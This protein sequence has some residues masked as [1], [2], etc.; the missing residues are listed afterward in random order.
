MSSNLASL[1]AAL[2]ATADGVFVLDRL[3]NHV[4]SN[5]P[6]ARMWK[7]PDSMLQG[8]PNRVLDL[9]ALQILDSETI[10][11]KIRKIYRRPL[12]ESRDLLQTRDGRFIEMHSRPH[13]EDGAISGRIWTFQD[14]SEQMI[15][16]DELV[17]AAF[18]DPLTGL[19]NRSL[20]MNSLDRL[21][22]LARP[23]AAM[24]AV[25]FLDLD[26]FKVINDG[27]GHLAGDL[28][29]V[30][31]ARKLREIVPQECM[32]ARL[33]GDEFTVL[34]ESVQSEREIVLIVERILSEIKAP[35]IIENHEIFSTVSIG[36]AFSN[37]SYVRPEEMIRDADTAMYQAKRSG[38]SRF[39]I[40]QS[41]MRENAVSLMRNESDLRRALSRQELEIHY[42]PVVDANSRTVIGVEALV[43]WQHPER[44]FVPPLEFVTLAEET[45]LIVPL[46]EW[47]LRRACET[48]A[49]LNQNGHPIYMAVNLSSLQLRQPALVKMVSDALVDSGVAASLLYLELTE[50]ALMDS[51]DRALRILHDLREMGVSLAIDDFGTGYSSL[52]YLKRFPVNGLKI[53][54][55]FVKDIPQEQST[56]EITRVIIAMS[57][58]L[59]LR[60]VAEGVET[61]SQL[62]FLKAEGCENIQGYFFSRPVPEDTLEA[63][64]KSIQIGS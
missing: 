13:K 32:V 40:F 56:C 6:F 4:V 51:D 30:E 27:L 9:M 22:T 34:V 50:T 49:K 23:G 37:D 7:V 47:V 19:P 26:R 52:S 58:I 25:F 59:G 36:V 21:I 60:V 3:G 63:C 28:L 5:K 24:F 42:Q 18:H 31:I 17:H 44:G 15:A 29:L 55:S 64:I 54:R 53:D 48:A 11:D 10:V 62:E 38:K 14:I 39:K 8:D 43:R 57:R 16:R 61:Q 1:R 33:G 20:F 41:S 35:V 45:G 46:G 12:D 2:D